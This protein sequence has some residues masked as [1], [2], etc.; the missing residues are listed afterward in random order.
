MQF[1][2]IDIHFPLVK[3]VVVNVGRCS[4]LAQGRCSGGNSLNPTLR[5]YLHVFFWSVIINWPKGNLRKY[6]IL[7]KYFG[8]IWRSPKSGFFWSCIKWIQSIDTAQFQ[9]N[10]IFWLCIK[11]KN[12]SKKESLEAV[13]F[14]YQTWCD[15]AY[16]HEYSNGF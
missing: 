11:I 1:N 6:D 13:S 14:N 16:F 15:L 12:C 3:V 4:E 5:L 7:R 8:K 10:Q 9:I 2:I